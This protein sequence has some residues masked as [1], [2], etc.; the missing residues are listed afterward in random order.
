MSNRIAY[1][2]TCV[3][4]FA[5]LCTPSAQSQPTEPAAGITRQQISEAVQGAVPR[6][7]R[8]NG[9]LDQAPFKAG[10]LAGV[11][12]AIY[13]EESG[14]VALWSEIQNVEPDASGHFTVLLGATKNGGLPPDVLGVGEPRWLSVTPVGGPAQARVLLVSVPY[15]L[16]AEE[17]LRI[18]GAPAGDLVRKG[19]LT[20]SVREALRSI[21]S[22]GAGGYARPNAIANATSGPTTFSGSTTNQIVSVKQTG[23][24]KGLIVTAPSAIATIS[25]GGTAGVYGSATSSTGTGVQGVATS[26]TGGASVG[27][28][29]ISSS[30]A[31][32]GVAGQGSAFGVTGTAAHAGGVGVKGTSTDTSDTTGIDI[33]VQGIAYNSTGSG[34]QGSN[35]ATTGYAFGVSGVTASTAGTGVNG[36]ALATSGYTKC[37][38]D[39]Q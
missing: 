19:D 37:V 36:N 24:G 8:F 13:K 31:G 21:Q 11:E 34:V 30:S 32:T 1:A 25:T 5:I 29:G 17:A 15:A 27:V 33:G 7:I 28:S 22:D 14:G 18:A 23:T 38:W 10:G 9:T 39:R 6:L 20:D 26:T 3:A 16:R 2:F 4:T 12:F 35:R